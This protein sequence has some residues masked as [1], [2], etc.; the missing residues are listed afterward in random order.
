MLFR[1]GHGDTE[2]M[3]IKHSPKEETDEYGYPRGDDKT[4]LPPAILSV[5]LN[6]RMDAP[7]K[8]GK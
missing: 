4:G 6:L 7:L 1:T 3:K 2:H 8:E 5:L